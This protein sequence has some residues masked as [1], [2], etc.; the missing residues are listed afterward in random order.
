MK[1]NPGRD[2]RFPRDHRLT[3]STA[4]RK[5]FA[6]PLRYRGSGYLVLFRANPTGP[7]RLGLAIAKKCARRA[8]DRARLK[9]IARESFR[10][11]RDRLH[12]WDIVVL[13][14]PAAPTMSNERLFASLERAWM[15]IE[16]QTCVAS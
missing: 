14:V 11:H 9:R 7:A 16:N 8:V 4:F 1:T 6:A 13:C 15:T 12:G 3:T 5:V 10:R 2:E